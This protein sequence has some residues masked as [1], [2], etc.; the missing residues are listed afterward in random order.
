MTQH[1]C[2]SSALRT[3]WNN[4][5]CEDKE[6]LI[7][8]ES[9]FITHHVCLFYIAS[10][11][12]KALLLRLK[13]GGQG[14][15]LRVGCYAA[16]SHSSPQTQTQ[17]ALPEA[18]SIGNYSVVLLDRE[19]QGNI[20]NAYLFMCTRCLR[21][22]KMAILGLLNWIIHWIES[23]QIILNWIIYW[24]EFSQNGFELNN[25]LNW[26]FLKQFWIK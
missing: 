17:N 10:T 26:I 12:R 20:I 6:Q 19:V 23:Q 15:I 14:T 5:D 22:P 11:Q 4:I 24:I 8:R 2:F 7:W 3:Q 13:V 21:R 16:M 25:L 1:V 9:N 18:V